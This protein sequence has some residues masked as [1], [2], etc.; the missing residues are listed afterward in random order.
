MTIK[1][2]CDSHCTCCL[3]GIMQQQTKRG[4]FRQGRPYCKT[5]VAR[6]LG[7]R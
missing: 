4:G 3:I 1:K 7:E 6:H 5:T 2:K